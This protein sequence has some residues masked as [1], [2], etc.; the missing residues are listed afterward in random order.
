MKRNMMPL[1]VLNMKR[2]WTPPKNNF[3][4]PSSRYTVDKQL[5]KPLY[6]SLAPGRSGCC[7]ASF[8]R[9]TSKGFVNSVP[10]RLPNSKSD[11]RVVIDVL[12]S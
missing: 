3:F 7:V 2:G 4:S 11:R 9:Q 8:D 1:K 10:I 6:L 12:I 5:K